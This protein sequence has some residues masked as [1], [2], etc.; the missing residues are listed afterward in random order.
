MQMKQ[1]YHW[2]SYLWSF[3]HTITIANSND[4]LEYNTHVKSILQSIQYAIPCPT[5]AYTYKEFLNTLDQI[6]LTKPMV[7]FY[8]SVDLHNLVNTKLSK[9]HISYDEAI[10][11]WTKT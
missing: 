8:W 1:K 2:G 9:P 6:D 5:C 4:N 10:Y 3:I 11:M 7:L